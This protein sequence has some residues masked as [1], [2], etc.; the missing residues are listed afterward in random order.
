MTQELQGDPSQPV[1]SEIRDVIPDNLQAN[2][3]PISELL[4]QFQKVLIQSASLGSFQEINLILLLLRNFLELALE[5]VEAPIDQPP[6]LPVEKHRTTSKP[7]A[8]KNISG[9]IFQQAFQ[10]IR[11]IA[12]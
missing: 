5:I 6:S 11:S 2:Y 9:N 4:H 3:Q 10:K 12:P 8:T 7:E 1:S